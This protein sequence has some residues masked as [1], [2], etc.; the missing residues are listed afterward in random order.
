MGALD[1]FF[2]LAGNDEK[3]LRDPAALE[4][5]MIEWAA[6]VKVP[7]QLVLPRQSGA[8]SLFPDGDASWEMLGTERFA[9]NFERFDVNGGHLTMMEDPKLA[10]FLEFGARK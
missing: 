10:Q 7:M 8:R 9:K 5:R 1:L 6:R 3:I 4:Q 2:T